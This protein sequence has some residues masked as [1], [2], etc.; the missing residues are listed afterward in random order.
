[1]Q[2]SAKQRLCQKA[3]ACALML[4]CLT[5]IITS[6]SAPAQGQ[7][8]NGPRTS[9]LIDTTGGNCWEDYYCP[10]YFHSC[11]SSEGMQ[12]YF[13]PDPFDVGAY[14]DDQF[15]NYVAIGSTYDRDLNGVDDRSCYG[16]CDLTLNQTGSVDPSCYA[17]CELTG[18]LQGGYAACLRNAFG[19]TSRPTP[20]GGTGG[21]A[22][23]VGRVAGNIFRSCVAGQVPQLYADEYNACIANGGSVEECCSLVSSHFP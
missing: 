19:I 9:P 11:A 12:P 23:N 20:I 5:F 16:A 8:Y 1:M 13:A 18:N 22:R 10:A 4:G 21:D 14:C 17:N 3:L 7:C 15:I 2:D 6:F